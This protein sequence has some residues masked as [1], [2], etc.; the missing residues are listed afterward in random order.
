MNKKQKDLLRE[1][2]EKR[3]IIKEEMVWIGC[4]PSDPELYKKQSDEGFR[5]MVKLGKLM[6]EYDKKIREAEK[7][8]D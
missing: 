8:G 4:N 2:M 1:F 3:A 5:L 7:D 6:I